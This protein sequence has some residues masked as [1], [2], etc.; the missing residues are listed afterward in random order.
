MQ[1]EPALVQ[2]YLHPLKALPILSL[3]GYRAFPKLL[4][5]PHQLVCIFFL[6]QWHHSLEILDISSNSGVS[7]ESMVLL[8]NSGM[9][10]LY[11]LDLSSTNVT[12][13]GVR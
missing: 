9:P 4:P 5:F 10:K 3:T 6:F 11:S 2:K 12:A 13:E 7:D 8:K 1:F